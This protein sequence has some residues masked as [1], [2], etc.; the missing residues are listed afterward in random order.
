MLMGVQRTPVDA[1]R[2][3]PLRWPG[4]GQPSPGRAAGR[5]VWSD[6]PV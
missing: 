1:R 2:Q 6:H 3:A 4:S 5:T